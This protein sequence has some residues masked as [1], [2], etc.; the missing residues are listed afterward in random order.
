MTFGDIFGD[1]IF[2]LCITFFNSHMNKL[3][4]ELIYI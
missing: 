4:L 2:S 3:K 1:D